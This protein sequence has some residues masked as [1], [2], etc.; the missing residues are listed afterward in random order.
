MVL[1]GMDKICRFGKIFPALLREDGEP[2]Q[3]K[4]SG[5]TNQLLANKLHQDGS[6]FSRSRS[7]TAKMSSSGYQI[8]DKLIF[9]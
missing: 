7:D 3:N 8:E 1:V 2:L 6:P 5:P 9:I 4:C